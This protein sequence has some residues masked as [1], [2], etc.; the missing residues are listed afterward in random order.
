MLTLEQR[1]LAVLVDVW[2]KLPLIKNEVEIA[3]KYL[4]R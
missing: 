3:L 4:A 1:A 2:R